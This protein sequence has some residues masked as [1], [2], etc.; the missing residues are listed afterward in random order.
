MSTLTEK[1][2]C[3]VDEY[4]VDLNA[5]QAAIR[6]GYSEDSARS[7]GSENLQKPD[8]AEA[9]AAARKARADRTRIDADYV[10]QTVRETV[11][12]CRQT[13]RPILDRKGEHVV[14]EDRDGSTALAYE[15]DSKGVLKGCELLGRNLMLWKDRVEHTGKDGTPLIPPTDDVAVARRLAFLL[16][17]GTQ[18]IE[19]AHDF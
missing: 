2:R 8:V 11:E 7:I 1:Q 9:I 12:R 15:F 6:A 16:Q 3:F 19:P 14:T 18:A 10:L 4:L 13:V 17:K 5:T